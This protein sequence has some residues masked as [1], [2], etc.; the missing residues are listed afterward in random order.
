MRKGAGV[1][2]IFRAGLAMVV[3]ALAIGISAWLLRSA[4][5]GGEA[6]PEVQIPQVTVLTIN[7]GQHHPERV[8]VGEVVAQHRVE[9]LSPVST[10]VLAT[11]LRAG[12]WVQRHERLLHLDATELQAQLERLRLESEQ[13]TLAQRE[14]AL[15]LERGQQAFA[16]EQQ[17]L[18]QT[19]LDL[20]RAQALFAQGASSNAALE[21]LERQVL[22][23]EQALLQRQTQFT[24]LE[25]QQAQQQVQQEQLVLQRAQAQRDQD[26]AELRAPL[27][28]WVEQL[29][30]SVGQ[31]VSPGQ[32]LMT[33]YDPASLVWQVQ[34]PAALAQYFDAWIDDRWQSPLRIVPNPARPSVGPRLEFALPQAVAWR[35][36]E[37]HSVRLRQRVQGPVQLIP[38][39][40]LYGGDRLFVVQPNGHLD[41]VRVQP[42]GSLRRAEQAYWV[43]AAS[44][45]PEGGQI[46]VS[47]L[48]NPLPGQRVQVADE[49]KVD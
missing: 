49:L 18:A 27:S 34:V 10:D 42:L 41:E 45:L 5:N 21:A 35:P 20:T 8:W 47:R 12:D 24:Q 26:R 15:Q 2:N 13:L 17:L 19:R 4:E 43:L 40:A 23:A 31:R 28:G 38:D 37:M 30:V 32:P 36:G 7:P 16:L 6:E 44:Q 3:L 14:S 9:V 29:N 39:S 33:L 48:P 46:L 1:H 22:Q 25:L 11:P